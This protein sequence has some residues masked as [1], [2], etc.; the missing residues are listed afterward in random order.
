V[1]EYFQLSNREHLI[2][3]LICLRF[4]KQC[5]SSG[6]EKEFWQGNNLNNNRLYFMENKGDKIKIKQEEKNKPR[7]P[8]S[9]I[10]LANLI[11]FRTLRLKFF[12]RFRSL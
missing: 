4:S 1:A 8:Q 12:S 2:K 5:K 6:D 3:I 7:K 10:L 11:L 9:I